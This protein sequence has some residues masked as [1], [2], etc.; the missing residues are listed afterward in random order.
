M[1]ILYIL[2]SYQFTINIRNIFALLH[3]TSTLLHIQTHMN[4][5]VVSVQVKEIVMGIIPKGM[6]VKLHP[7]GKVTPALKVLLV[8]TKMK[9]CKIV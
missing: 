1:Y 8:T 3:T 4:M 5:W 2:V 6:S 7:G 9:V